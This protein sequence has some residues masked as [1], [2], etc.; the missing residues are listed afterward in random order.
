MSAQ[1]ELVSPAG[2]VAAAMLLIVVALVGDRLGYG[3]L[4]STNAISVLEVDRGHP[5]VSL[6]V[7][8]TDLHDPATGLLVN[9][10]EQGW[11][12]ER[13]GSLSY[14]D[15]GKLQFSSRA[16]IRVHGGSSRL[17]SSV[18]S[19]RAYFRDEYGAAVIEAGQLFNGAVGRVRRLV[20]H[21]DIRHYGSP[22]APWSFANPLAYDISARIG[23]IVPHTKPVRFFLNGEW[24]GVYVV[25]EHVVPENPDFFSARW[26]HDQFSTDLEAMEQLW[27]W[28]EDLE[29][30]V[31]M[32][33]IARRINVDNL[34]RWFLSALFCGTQDAFQG[35]GQFHDDTRDLAA[36]F[37][38][39]WDMDGSF[40]AWNDDAFYRLLEQPN[41]ARRGRRNSEPRAKVLTHLLVGDRQ[42]EGDPIY[43]EYFKREF[44]RMLN[45]QV[46]QEFLDERLAHYNRLAHM[47]GIE[48]FRFLDAFEDF[49]AKRRD[50]LWSLAH[51]QFNTGTAVNLK[52]ISPKGGVDVD[53]TYVVGT[54]EGRYFPN[55]NLELSL[56]ASSRRRVSHW[57]VNGTR[58]AEG[59][60][61]LRLLVDSD[62]TI[63]P[64]LR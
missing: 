56:P 29:P 24:Q 20:L 44:M 4:Q 34:T 53:G 42:H 54:F 23:A 13:P 55:M 5:L 6:W 49:L 50:F 48:D 39:N 37:W 16:G 51:Q 47:Y 25:T 2:L 31:T 61:S 36:W 59:A 30:P 10:N 15:Q 63:E 40:R 28:V 64:V 45:H 52:V 26:G 12:W 17:T 14:F 27:A 21:N 22:P 35:P 41:V 57:L 62:L 18:Q 58:K 33:T 8:P 3:R 11:L 60:P 46:T 19:F 32:T 9:P 1:R 7:N 43:I 38:I